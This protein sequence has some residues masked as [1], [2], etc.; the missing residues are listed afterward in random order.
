MS[1]F[2][3]ALV[4]QTKDCV[5]LILTKCVQE[6]DA[7][8]KSI[9]GLYRVSGV[10][11]Q[12][13]KLYQSFENSAELVDLTDTH[14]NVIANVLKLYLRQLPE[15]LL[16]FRL[17]PEFVR[18]AKEF[19]ASSKDHS[20]SPTES[21]SSPEPPAPVRP[22]RLAQLKAAE[23]A[24]DA[25]FISV[26]DRTT[27][28]LQL[29]GR[30]IGVVE[31]L[32]PAHHL[33]LS[34]LIHHLRRIA[35]NHHEN[36]MPSSNLGIVFGP[37]LLRTSDGSSLSSLVDTVHQ[38]RAVELLITYANEVFGLA[39]K[40]DLKGRLVDTTNTSSN[41]SDHTRSRSASRANHSPI[42]TSST[43][44]TTDSESPRPILRSATQ[45]SMAPVIARSYKVDF[46]RLNN[47]QNVQHV[48]HHHLE[49][50]VQRAYSSSAIIK[51]A[52]Q[53]VF[54]SNISTGGQQQQ[55]Q[56]PQ[57]TQ[58]TNTSNNKSSN[59]SL[60]T[61]SGS[62]NRINNNKDCDVIDGSQTTREHRL[63]ASK[64]PS[65]SELRRQFFTEL[66]GP[67]GQYLGGRTCPESMSSDLG[68]SLLTST[69]A[70]VT[71]PLSSPPHLK[72]LTVP[73]DTPESSDV[74]SEPSPTGFATRYSTPSSTSGTSSAASALNLSHSP[75]PPSMSNHS[76]TPTP[77]PHSLRHRLT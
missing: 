56:Q 62:H 17:Y 27:E 63:L 73:I 50:N 16:T 66:T 49:P 57:H 40:L 35:D 67:E 61:R 2:G 11:S 23:R 46:H 65:I 64:R 20:P 54:T 52:G 29:I 74:S 10:K 44:L 31:K 58:S 30:L 53:R 69:P 15:P 45:A 70:T 68:L 33:T 72:R 42:S 41:N 28:Q 51:L 77:Q 14:P 5:P 34:F 3:V 21:S 71:P 25:C 32:P 59:I 55:Q 38:T 48:S 47:M 37:T 26:S 18:V 22:P 8:G 6:I 13:E 7:K 75:Q 1:T 19:P 9:K 43:G 12:V 24:R 39:P 36:N 4:H 76:P 60:T